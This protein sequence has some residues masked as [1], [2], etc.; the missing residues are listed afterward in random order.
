MKRER[1][2]FDA[3]KPTFEDRILGR[4]GPLTAEQEQALALYCETM[5]AAMRAAALEGF[6]A[7]LIEREAEYVARVA[8]DD[9]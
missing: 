6:R 3:R 4:F 5:K 8:S 1:A 7:V 2:A 9:R